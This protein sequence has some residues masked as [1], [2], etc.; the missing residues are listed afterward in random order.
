VSAVRVATGVVEVVSAVRVATG[1]KEVKT[2]MLPVFFATLEIGA[3]V[4]AAA[5]K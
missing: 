4:T 1:V 3:T 2:I 5:V